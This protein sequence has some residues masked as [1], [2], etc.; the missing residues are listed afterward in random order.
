MNNTVKYALFPFCLLLGFFT[1]LAYANEL[2]GK[3]I[4]YAHDKKTGELVYIEEHI[5]PTLTEHQVL[6]STPEGQVFATKNLD[7]VPSTIAPSFNQLNELNGEWI[8][9]K[10]K[11]NTLL[12]TYRET[13]ESSEKMEAIDFV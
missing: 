1:S 3:A 6:Y 10:N 8:D 11:T 9:V 2:V 13:G 4:G 12:V 5:K 7:Y